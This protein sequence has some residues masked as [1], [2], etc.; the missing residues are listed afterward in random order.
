MNISHKVKNDVWV[1][2]ECYEV[3][4]QVATYITFSVC[5]SE[6]EEESVTMKKIGRKGNTL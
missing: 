4:D 3:K 5:A 2:K 6:I 1:L